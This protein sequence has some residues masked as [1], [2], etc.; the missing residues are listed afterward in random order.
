[1]ATEDNLPPMLR[2]Q[3]QGGSQGGAEEEKGGEARTAGEERLAKERWSG[4]EK[5]KAA[6]RF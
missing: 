5:G 4:T 1:M 6:S 3:A 2:D